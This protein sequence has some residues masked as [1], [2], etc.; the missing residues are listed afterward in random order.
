MSRNRNK[1]VLWEGMPYVCLRKTQD[2]S[3]ISGAFKKHIKEASRK[4]SIETTKAIL[5]GIYPSNNKRGISVINDLKDRNKEIQIDLNRSNIPDNSGDAIKEYKFKL[6]NGILQIPYNKNKRRGDNIDTHYKLMMDIR[7]PSN[8]CEYRECKGEVLNDA[9]IFNDC[10]HPDLKKIRLDMRQNISRAITNTTKEEIPY[11]EID[12]F[13]DNKVFTKNYDIF[14]P[15]EEGL[16]NTREP[17]WEILPAIFLPA[18]VIIIEEEH[19]EFTDEHNE[20]LTKVDEYLHSIG[21]SQ[22]EID[23]RY[24]ERLK[25]KNISE[26]GRK[27][28]IEINKRKIKLVTRRIKGNNRRKLKKLIKLIYGRERRWRKKNTKLF[29]PIIRMLTSI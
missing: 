1:P 2:R 17:D 16:L 6:Q 4:A 12:A 18:E 19:E 14:E 15:K 24:V 10:K 21:L 7:F 26:A 22:E 13:I 23:D 29:P 28:V 8:L 11:D 25:G 20:K 3:I 5:N 27:K 9:H